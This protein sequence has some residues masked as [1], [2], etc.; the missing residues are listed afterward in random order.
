MKKFA[1]LLLAVVFGISCTTQ[2]NNPTT[3]EK[4]DGDSFLNGLKTDGGN[5]ILVDLR[6]PTECDY[7]KQKM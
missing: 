3:Y 1:I 7:G 6:T 2:D 4:V 5:T